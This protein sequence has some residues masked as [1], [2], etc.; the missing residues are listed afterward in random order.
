MKHTIILLV[1]L[2]CQPEK[3]TSN[4][5]VHPKDN[6]AEL[7]R[8]VGEWGI[9]SIITRTSDSEGITSC[10]VCPKIKF[11]KNLIAIVTFSDNSID[12]LN[13]NIDTDTMKLKNINP[14]RQERYFSDHKYLM[15]FQKKEKYTELSLE[16]DSSYVYVLRR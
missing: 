2:S 15:I 10:N 14:K 12:S 11:D 16:L 7:K 8:V 6:S 3:N 13:W 4:D 1:L 9:Y 5:I